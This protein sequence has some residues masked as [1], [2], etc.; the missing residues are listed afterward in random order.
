VAVDAFLND[1]ISFLGM[2]A[3]ISKCMQNVPYIK[4]PS[5]ADFVETNEESRRKAMEFVINEK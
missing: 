1:R 2:S 5:F 3:V 4:K